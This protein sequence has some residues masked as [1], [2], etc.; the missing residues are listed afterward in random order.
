MSDVI[1]NN[2]SDIFYIQAKLTIF[3]Y[4]NDSFFIVI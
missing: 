3:P 1:L 2:E 4:S